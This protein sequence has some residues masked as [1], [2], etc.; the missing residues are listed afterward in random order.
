MPILYSGG[1]GTVQHE[2]NRSVVLYWATPHAALGGSDVRLT[3]QQW[4]ALRNVPLCSCTL[5]T[6][7]IVHGFFFI[8]FAVR[9]KLKG[10]TESRKSFFFFF[11]F[12]MLT[13]WV[14][15]LLQ[16]HI[17]TSVM[18]TGWLQHFWLHFIHCTHSIFISNVLFDRTCLLHKGKRYL[19]YH[20]CRIP[21]THWHQYKIISFFK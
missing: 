14:V 12:T 19:K 1:V 5:H 16:Q 8:Y 13:C 20:I 9:L 17:T 10:S 11:F 6:N 15:L 18:Y 4:P 21:T 7:G 3:T 2:Y